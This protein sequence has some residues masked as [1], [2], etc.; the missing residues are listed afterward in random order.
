MSNLF[1]KIVGKL[2]GDDELTK[3]E[4]LI[5]QYWQEDREIKI[6]ESRL[7]KYTPEHNRIESEKITKELESLGATDIMLM[8]EKLSGPK[9]KF[10]LNDEKI[11]S[12]EIFD[13]TY[14]KVMKDIR[15]KI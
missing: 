5:S 12:D 15:K 6:Q 14:E 10:T 9:L 2:I 13:F 7:V 3:N 1:D 4:K 8:T 11:E